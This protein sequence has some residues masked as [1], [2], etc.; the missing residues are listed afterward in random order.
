MP[1]LWSVEVGQ[2]SGEHNSTC[3]WLLC[4]QLAST[5][6]TYDPFCENFYLQLG[7]FSFLF[8]GLNWRQKRYFLFF[9]RCRIHFVRVL[10]RYTNEVIR[11]YAFHMTLFEGEYLQQQQK[12]NVWHFRIHCLANIFSILRKD[13]LYSVLYFVTLTN[14]QLEQETGAYKC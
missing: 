8:L 12:S 5:S 4:L 11:Y 13:N 10:T 9:T 1:T 6:A 14:T 2:S 3:R 7:L